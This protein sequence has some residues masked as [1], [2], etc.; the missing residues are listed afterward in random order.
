MASAVP[1]SCCKSYE[2][3]CAQKPYGKHPSN[4][5]YEVFRYFFLRPSYVTNIVDKRESEIRNF[6]YNSRVVHRHSIVF[7][8]HI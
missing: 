8:I 1:D 2:P 4:I 3:K 5:F 7:I 6:I